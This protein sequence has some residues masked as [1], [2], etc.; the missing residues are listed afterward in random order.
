[1]PKHF[2][3]FLNPRALVGDL[4][5]M[6]PLHTPI[7]DLVYPESVQ[8]NHPFSTIGYE[9]IGTGIKNI[10]LVSRGASSYAMPLDGTKLR[11][12]EPQ[13]LTP[14][15]FIGAN[16]LNDMKS[17]SEGQQKQY[18]LNKVDQ[19]RRTVRASKE[20]LAIQSL[21]GKIEYGVRNAEGVIE[22]YTVDFGNT[23]TTTISKK[24]DA[25]G[26]KASNVIKDVGA[27]VAEIKSGS[28]ATKF[29]GFI[30]FDTYAAIVD[31]VNNASQKLPITVSEDAIIIGAV[32]LY[33]TAATYYDYVAKA[34]KPLIAAKNVMV[35]GVDDGFKF[36]NCALDSLEADFAGIP[37]GVREVPKDDPEG[38]DLIGMAR[39]MPIPNV[40]AI[41]VSTCLS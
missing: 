9:D 6:P 19:L 30:D 38:V 11:F 41:C 33:V 24:W 29:I 3:K 23:K 17:F 5:K 34:N 2:S 18:I 13:N 26:A 10:P 35:I 20:A 1:M 14:S 31:L 12:I 37:F 8:V 39:P 22:K 28:N 4:N 36:F 27:M 25:G 15:H 16:K 21:T 7:L 40:N 32:T